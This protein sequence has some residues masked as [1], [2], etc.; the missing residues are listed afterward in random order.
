MTKLL[1]RTFLHSFLKMAPLGIKFTLFEMI[2][3][4]KNKK[5][6]ASGHKICTFLHERLAMSA[7]KV[8]I[9]WPR[10]PFFKRS[11]KKSCL[12]VLS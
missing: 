9:L 1:K 8:Q 2:F 7:N 12:T 10:V 6:G 5:D 4:D 3:H 11:A